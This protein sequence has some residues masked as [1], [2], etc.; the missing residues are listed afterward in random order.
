MLTYKDYK[1][2]F[3]AKREHG[4][5]SQPMTEKQFNEMMGITTDDFHEPFL[6]R[7]SASL[8]KIKPTFEVYNGE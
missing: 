3:F 1:A 5:S 6:A 7:K 2:Q 4:Y 8:K